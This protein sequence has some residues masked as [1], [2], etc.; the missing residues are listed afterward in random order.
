MEAKTGNDCLLTYLF[1]YLNPHLRICLL[2]LEREE[3]MFLFRERNT[4]GCLRSRPQLR[5]EP[6]TFW[7][8]DDAPS[9]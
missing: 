9:S 6:A 1:T 4:D 2:T 7:C 8:T 5:T 3:G